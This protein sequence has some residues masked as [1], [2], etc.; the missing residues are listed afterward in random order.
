MAR[1]GARH[2]TELE[3]QRP[4][5]P[6]HSYPDEQVTSDLRFRVAAALREVGL[7]GTTYAR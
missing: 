2:S 1:M 6:L 4:L 3:L 7:H 5:F